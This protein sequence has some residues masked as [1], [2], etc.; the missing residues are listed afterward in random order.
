[1]KFL[2]FGVIH[3]RHQ[4]AKTLKIDFSKQ[5]CVVPLCLCLPSEI[6]TLLNFANDKSIVNNKEEAIQLGRS[7]FHRGGHFS[8]LS[9][10]SSNRLVK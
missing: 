2:Q 5:F 7:P 10:L 4:D 1:M 8:G 9:G 3:S 6:F